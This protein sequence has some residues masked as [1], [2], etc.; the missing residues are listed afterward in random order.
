MAIDKMINWS[1]I[2]SNFIDRNNDQWQGNSCH[3]FYQVFELA[4]SVVYQPVM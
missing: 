2:K 1:N 3:L 4:L